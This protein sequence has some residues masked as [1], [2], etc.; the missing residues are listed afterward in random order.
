[1]KHAAILP[2]LLLSLVLAGCAT[3]GTMQL[4]DEAR[5]LAADATFQNEEVKDASGFDWERRKIGSTSLPPSRPPST[6]N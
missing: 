2:V 5:P 4:S 3:H 6:G 1:M